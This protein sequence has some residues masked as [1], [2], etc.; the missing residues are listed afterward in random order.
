MHITSM[1]ITII[2]G[3]K[4]H[5]FERGQEE[6]YGRFGWRKGKGGSDVIIISKDKRSS[7]N[8]EKQN[9]GES[10]TCKAVDH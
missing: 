1:Y 8:K 9:R 3:G 10:K 7:N 2:N 6:A 4:G 5:E